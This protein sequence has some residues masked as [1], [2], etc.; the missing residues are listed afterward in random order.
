M[1]DLNRN[2]N[3]PMLITHNLPI[4]PTL[5]N[6]QMSPTVPNLQTTPTVPNLQMSPTLPVNNNKF[7]N[8]LNLKTDFNGEFSNYVP[9]ENNNDGIIFNPNSDIYNDFIDNT[10]SDTLEK[11]FKLMSIN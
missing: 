8:L 1:S 9:L 11:Y 2:Y 10:D 4:T 5:P 3:N 7:N 6:L